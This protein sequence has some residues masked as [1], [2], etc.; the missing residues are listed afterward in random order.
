MEKWNSIDY[1][2]SIPFYKPV[3]F[4]YSKSPPPPTILNFSLWEH[5]P[6]F[7]IPIFQIFTF[8][9]YHKNLTKKRKSKSKSNIS[10]PPCMYKYLPPSKSYNTMAVALKKSAI[11]TPPTTRHHCSGLASDPSSSTCSNLRKLCMI[12]SL[13]SLQGIRF[14]WGLFS[15]QQYWFLYQYSFSVLPVFYEDSPYE[16]PKPL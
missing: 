3:H 7:P 2:I 15:I 16:I 5:C 13:F 10:R 11:S 12:T 8:L 14:N 6:Q 9:G 4:T 1:P